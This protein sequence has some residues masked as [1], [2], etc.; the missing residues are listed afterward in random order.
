MKQKKLLQKLSVILG[1]GIVYYSSHLTAF[2]ADNSGGN[3]VTPTSAILSTF[4]LPMVVLVFLYLLMIRPQQKQE[5]ETRNMQE[6]L[7][8]GDEVITSG[9]I[10]GLVLRVDNNTKTV[11]LETGSNHVKIRVIQEAIVKNNTADE[12]AAA[13]KAKEK[14]DKANGVNLAKSKDE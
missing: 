8:V 6:N 1:A 5:K 7:Q 11:L 2:A 13:E 10:V 3:N 9:G 14:K 4:I 12:A